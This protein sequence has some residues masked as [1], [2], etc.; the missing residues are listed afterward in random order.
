MI[1]RRVASSSSKSGMDTQYSRSGTIDTPVAR[2]DGIGPAWHEHHTGLCLGELPSR[3]TSLS[4]SI[5]DHILQHY[6]HTDSLSRP[7]NHHSSTSILIR[8]PSVLVNNQPT[9][10]TRHSISQRKRNRVCATSHE[11]VGIH[12][13]LHPLTHTAIHPHIHGPANSPHLHPQYIARRQH[14]RQ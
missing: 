4:V 14:I 5:Y 7:R 12:P 6:N 13:H 8:S 11:L 3:R 9:T 10:S 1:N 2:I